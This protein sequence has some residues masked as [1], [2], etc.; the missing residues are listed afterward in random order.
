MSSKGPS[1]PGGGD[2]PALPEGWRDPDLEDHGE[3]LS[4]V[5]DRR[6]RDL[7]AF[8]PKSTG[9]AWLK[10]GLM[11]VFL[12]AIL[13]FHNHLS[14][15]AAGCYQQTAGLPAEPAPA[16]TSPPSKGGTEVQ[17]R[18]ERQPAAAP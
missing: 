7:R 2:K 17:I 14:D 18:I 10:L 4:Q 16:P 5:G 6:L 3:R 15:K 13:V 9:S 8:E 11:V 1:A 12:V